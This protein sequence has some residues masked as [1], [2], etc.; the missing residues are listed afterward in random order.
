MKLFKSLLTFAGLATIVS[1]MT[2]CG[3]SGKQVVYPDFERT[4]AELNSWEYLLDENG[5][6]II[7]DLF[8]GKYYTT[9]IGKIKLKKL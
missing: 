3:S 6:I 4:P 9:K 5:K 2:G 1:F 8:V 7:K